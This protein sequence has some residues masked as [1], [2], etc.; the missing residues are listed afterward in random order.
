MWIT[1]NQINKVN[2]ILVANPPIRQEFI[3]ETNYIYTDIS[4]ITPILVTNLYAITIDNLTI[5]KQ[6]YGDLIVSVEY[7]DINDIISSITTDYNLVSIELVDTSKCYIT[8]Y[9]T[10]SNSNLNNLYIFSSNTGNIN[11][12]VTYS[13]SN[14]NQYA[15]IDCFISNHSNITN[16]SYQDNY[17][18][19]PLAITSNFLTNKAFNVNNIVNITYLFSINLSYINQNIGFNTATINK[20]NARLFSFSSVSLVNTIPYIELD[21]LIYRNNKYFNL[22][23]IDNLFD[24]IN[25]NVDDSQVHSFLSNPNYF[26][27]IDKL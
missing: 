25:N 2:S 13:I 19:I 9:N 14:I 5:N 22:Y 23:N 11:I 16:I 3:D 27:L 21:Y 7:T 18:S 24:Y 8:N 17:S 4:T 12:E 15:N 20:F 10:Q 1:T 26:I 6:F